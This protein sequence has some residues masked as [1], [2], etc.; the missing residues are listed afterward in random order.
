MVSEEEASS[1]N[2]Q[3]HQ[4]DDIYRAAGT[5]ILS[6]LI[7]HWCRSFK[8]GGIWLLA[9]CRNEACHLLSRFRT[10][11]YH[12]S[13]EQHTRIRCTVWQRALSLSPALPGWTLS[14]ESS[15][16]RDAD[17]GVRRHLT[18]SPRTIDAKK[19]LE[20]NCTEPKAARSDCAAKPA[21][22]RT[23]NVI[24]CRHL[25]ACLRLLRDYA[26]APT[27][28]EEVQHVANNEEANSKLPWLVCSATQGV[29]GSST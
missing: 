13:Q 4:E 24:D 9:W 23:T 20:T 25:K 18:F 6:N 28:G 17:S 27:E 14:T 19:T 16:W 5:K 8:Q 12:N 22:P 2:H 21:A 29:I 1:G 26:R 7:G 3:K 11:G 15:F 10:G